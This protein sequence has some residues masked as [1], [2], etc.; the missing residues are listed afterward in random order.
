MT[1]ENKNAPAPKAENDPDRGDQKAH[2]P[3]D[4]NTL[5]QR[6]K[7]EAISQEKTSVAQRASNATPQSKKKGGQSIESL[8]QFIGKAYSLKG[9]RLSLSAA[10]ERRIGRTPHLDEEA[11]GRLHTKSR[12]DK[13]FVVPRQLLLIAREIQ[14]YPVL[15]SEL[16]RFI[17]QV[18]ISRP[19]FGKYGLM[20]AIDNLDGAPS[21][22]EALS[23][24]AK[25]D[26]DLQGLGFPKAKSK[27]TE[28]NMLRISLVSFL[29][30]WF[31]DTR[32]V[33]LVQLNEMLYRVLWAP[34]AA[35]LIDDASRLRALTDIHD[36]VGVG[37]ACGVFVAAAKESSRMETAAQQERDAAQEQ[38]QVL[39]EE[40]ERDRYQFNVRIGYLE[41]EVS[42]LNELAER[43]R[44][45]GEVAQNHM[46]ADIERL[47]T[48]VLR[49]LNGDVALLEEGLTA[50]RRTPPKIHVMDDH[51]ERV[52]DALR[53]EISRLEKGN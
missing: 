52:A 27:A 43:H 40:I 47:R 25:C 14:T 21:I 33:T 6:L 29:V 9:R 30:L 4:T 35:E 39:K 10:V 3:L 26:G 51:G 16:Q 15:R 8:E 24:V 48:R 22:E 11:L 2:A 1:E 23:I 36:L 42:R 17:K 20:G 28:L 49:R 46:R 5:G 31:Y 18:V 38:R 50:L 12:D 32:A 41:G 13:L 19:I 7:G 45:D 34:R 44:R 53:Q 37:A